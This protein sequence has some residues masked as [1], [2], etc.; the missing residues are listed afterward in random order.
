MCVRQG[1]EWR[2]SRLVPWGFRERKG[3][4]THAAT[5]SSVHTTSCITHL[6]LRICCTRSSDISFI[7]KL[8]GLPKGEKSVRCR[9]FEEGA[10]R[11]YVCVFKVHVRVEARGEVSL[12]QLKRCVSRTWPRLHHLRSLTSCIFPLR[13]GDL[14]VLKVDG[15]GSCGSILLASACVLV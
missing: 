13:F 8:V 9:R 7:D 6:L 1:W 12:R 11:A 5:R 3:N 10:E 15:D 4:E 14:V 2:C